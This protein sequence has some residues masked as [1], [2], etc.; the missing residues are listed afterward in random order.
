MKETPHSVE[1]GAYQFDM[2]AI[3]IGAVRYGALLAWGAVFGMVWLAE[4]TIA[5]VCST[6]MLFEV[7]GACAAMLTIAEQAMLWAAIVGGVLLV[8][9]VGLPAVERRPGDRDG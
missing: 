3:A 4:R 2:L 5:P 9:G 7:T 1:I 6:S 8:I